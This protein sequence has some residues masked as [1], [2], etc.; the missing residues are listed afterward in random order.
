[1]DLAKF[2]AY[3]LSPNKSIKT[4]TVPYFQFLRI[5]SIHFF[6]IPERDADIQLAGAV[7]D[8]FGL[9]ETLK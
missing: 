5:E 7:L 4:R 1:M 8:F 6:Y 9:E 3:I 2:L